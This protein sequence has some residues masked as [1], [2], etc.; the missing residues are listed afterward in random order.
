MQGHYNWG[1]RDAS[2]YE[3]AFDFDDFGITGGVDYRYSE[4]TVA[5]IALSFSP[6]SLLP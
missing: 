4:A 5:G 3:D 6:T 2:Q 1:D